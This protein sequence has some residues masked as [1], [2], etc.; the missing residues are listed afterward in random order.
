MIILLTIP[1][2]ASLS[3]AVVIDSHAELSFCVLASPLCF[4]CLKDDVGN[5]DEGNG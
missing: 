1:Y 3:V 5:T 4:E 2:G